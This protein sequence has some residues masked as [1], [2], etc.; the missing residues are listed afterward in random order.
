MSNLLL[1][2]L[3]NTVQLSVTVYGFGETF[4]DGYLFGEILAKYNQQDDFAEFSSK[5]TP[6]V[7]LNNFRRLEPS[8]RKIGVQFNS[9]T[10]EDIMKVND[11]VVKTLLYEMKASL[12]R[13]QRNS[14]MSIGLKL[15]G[16]RHDRVISV[17]YNSRPAY[18]QTKSLTFQ[19]V[20]RGVLENPN[21]VLMNN[22]TKKF[23]DRED[24]Y[25]RTISTGEAMDWDSLT[26]QRTRAKE[27]YKSRKAHEGEFKDVWETMN[28]DQWRKNQIKAHT[29]KELFSKIEANILARHEAKVQKINEGHR[30]YTMKSMNDFD[31]KLEDMILPISS[32]GN[33]T[34][35]LKNS[36]VRTINV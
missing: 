7:A 32:E 28:I 26:L 2:W 27:I 1:D 25:F 13:L 6:L 17:V 3:N 10:V 23:T 11:K 5:G 19:N 12:E 16:T 24:G 18:D 20:V 22:V 21:D 31:K 15:R 35:D 36:F 8:M 30:N 29:R 9:R 33:G 14:T 34:D 4:R